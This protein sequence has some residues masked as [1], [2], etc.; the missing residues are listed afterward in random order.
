MWRFILYPFFIVHNFEA[1]LK[2]TN[3]EKT[4]DLFI[5]GET[6]PLTI[7]ISFA[8]YDNPTLESSFIERN[9][10]KDLIE[11][12]TEDIKKRLKNVVDGVSKNSKIKKF[13]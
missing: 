3:I 12:F 10:T 1:I 4:D 13:K 7:N 9:N 5:S 2:K 8:I 11:K 6:I